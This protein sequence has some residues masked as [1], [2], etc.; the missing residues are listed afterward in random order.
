M[1]RGTVHHLHAGWNDAGGDDARHAIAGRVRP[2]GEGDQQ[3]AH[4]RL[5][6]DAHGDFGD[7]AEQAFRA[8]DEAEQVVA[9]GIQV[10]A[11]EPHH[12]ARHQHDS[13]PSRLLVVRPYFRQCT[14]PEF[15]ATL[16]PIVQAI[17]D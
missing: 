11:A 6:Q 9:L 15:S 10:L 8:A 4:V 16:P 17:C 3:G 7:N 1:D 5:L 14:P 13:M 12:L 2:V